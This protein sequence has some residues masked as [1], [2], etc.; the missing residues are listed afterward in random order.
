MNADPKAAEAEV[1]I[2]RVSCVSKAGHSP[3]A[4][5]PRGVTLGHRSGVLAMVSGS[6]SPP[7]TSA[8]SA[9]LVQEKPQP[10]SQTTLQVSV[11]MVVDATDHLPLAIPLLGTFPISF[12]CFFTCHLQLPFSGCC[13]SDSLAVFVGR[14]GVSTC[15]LGVHVPH[16]SLPICLHFLGGPPDPW[17]LVSLHTGD[18]HFLENLVPSYHSVSKG[19]LGICLWICQRSFRFSMAT[20]DRITYSH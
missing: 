15:P 16:G 7:C 9:R 8:H 13:F 18:S 20:T 1:L 19:F 11:P 4:A 2:T 3:C 17:L 12:A 5:S 10:E 14:E 6:G